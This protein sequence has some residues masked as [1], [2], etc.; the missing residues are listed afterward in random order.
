MSQW[1]FN[2]RCGF[3]DETVI[4]NPIGWDKATVTIERDPLVKGL[5]IKYTSKVKF[6]SDGYQFIV[7]R[8]AVSGICGNLTIC[9]YK[10]CED[11]GE[12]D[13]WFEGIIY[14][15]DMTFDDVE[16][17]VE[18][19]IEDNSFGTFIQRHKNT[20]VPLNSG[21]TINNIPLANIGM[22]TTIWSA[23]GV[24]K[25]AYTTFPVYNV[26]QYI[27][28]YLSDNA[29]ILMSDFFQ[30]SNPL[31]DRWNIV[32]NINFV[33]GNTITTTWINF[34]GQTMVGVATYSTNQATT[35]LRVANSMLTAVP[36]G[37]TFKSTTIAF[38]N[39]FWRHTNKTDP[40][41]IDAYSYLPF[42]LVSSVVTG[43]ASQ[44]VATMTH[45]NTTSIGGGNIHIMGGA[46]LYNKLDLTTPNVTLAEFFSEVD[47]LFDISFRFYDIG[48]VPYIR[49]EQTSFFFSTASFLTINN[50]PNITWIFYLESY[51][52][53]L[54]CD[55]P[56]SKTV[57]AKLWEEESWKVGC[58]E[59]EFD[60]RNSYIIDTAVLDGT[61]M[62]T[63]TTANEDD[64]YFLQTCNNGTSSFNTSAGAPLYGYLRYLNTSTGVNGLFYPNN[65][66]ITN[67]HKIWAHFFS[68]GADQ[69]I[70]QERTITNTDSVRKQKL[71]QFDHY[72]TDMQFYN[73]L[74]SPVNKILFS[75]T[76][77]G[78]L[79]GWI[80]SI[81]YNI[82]TSQAHFKLLV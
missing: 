15:A 72:L 9:I 39:R 26:F 13:L 7:T 71:Y 31:Y 57:G 28:S 48:A 12:F 82:V 23:A 56:A 79:E 51:K 10:K 67:A 8:L 11:T 81:E 17:T 35:L 59:G 50:V 77:S 55:D 6:H 38:D 70:K 1:R 32:Y 19:R 37:M 63:I 68:L 64:I 58:Y 34:Y 47:K 61:L 78:H 74:V 75:D 52:Q 18:V 80:L 69:I 27:I 41:T 60:F 29:I 40:R 44:A 54:T 43:G 53:Q 14:F 33:T 66:D 49:I 46:H 76:T 30:L 24:N 25:G 16:C 5:F 62:G 45:P 22:N 20:V 73:I 3:P 2:A 65:T 4:S 42:T 36:A 21:R